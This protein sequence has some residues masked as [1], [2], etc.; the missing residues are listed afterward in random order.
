M[1]NKYRRP[2]QKG[3][4]VDDRPQ[5]T[6]FTCKRCGAN[7]LKVLGTREPSIIGENVVVKCDHCGIEAWLQVDYTFGPDDRPNVEVIP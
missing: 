4:F 6:P 5:V 3:M 2:G 7:A 1:E